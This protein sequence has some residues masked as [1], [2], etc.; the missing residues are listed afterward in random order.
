MYIP[1]E[2]AR[3]G[4]VA[5]F[6]QI[7]LPVFWVVKKAV[8]AAAVKGLKPFI[9]PAGKLFDFFMRIHVVTGQPAERLRIKALP[10]CKAVQRSI[11]IRLGQRRAEQARL[12]KKGG[13]RFKK[14][15]GGGEAPGKER[16]LLLIA[17]AVVIQLV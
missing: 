12:L 17:Q 4:K 13:Q 2:L 14:T 9:Q 16:D 11:G 1:D 6:R 8:D 10:L 7:S 3:I 15:E 5:V